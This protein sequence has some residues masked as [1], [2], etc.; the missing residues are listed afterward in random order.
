MEYSSL[1]SDNSKKKNLII[2]EINNSKNYLEEI[3]LKNGFKVILSQN[4][5]EKISISIY[6]KNP[7]LYQTFLNSGIENI[8]LIYIK[9]LIIEKLSKNLSIDQDVKI[10]I[11]ANK[12]LSKL[13]FL[14]S[15]KKDIQYFLEIIGDSLIIENFDFNE[16]LKIKN[17]VT[18]DYSNLIKDK[19]LNLN[20]L[21]ERH[22]FKTKNLQSFF[23]GNS[24]SLKLIK[25]DDVAQYYKENFT[26]ERLLLF[27]NGKIQKNDFKVEYFDQFENKF[28]NSNN[29]EV[30]FERLSNKD[31][32]NEP[33]FFQENIN[34][35]SF[36]SIFYRA[37]SFSND[38]YFA[39]LIV[40]KFFEE[41][42]IKNTYILEPPELLSNMLN[43][44][45]YG[46]VLFSTKNRDIQSTL[47]SFKKILDVQ[48]R[49]FGY[50]TFYK[51]NSND[52]VKDYKNQN[53]N[54]TF[55][56]TSSLDLEN[57]KEKVYNDFNFNELDSENKEIKFV[58]AYF[59]AGQIIDYVLIKE[60]IDSITDKDLIKIFD[61]YFFNLSWGV[62]TNPETSKIISK[63]F[64][65]R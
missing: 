33:I 1:F 18:L 27:V 41:N 28:K 29:K 17:Q 54:K 8:L 37:P 19:K 5:N 40:L 22:I 64:F 30:E 32:N 38:E 48:K 62:L 47:L 34:D 65:Y 15:Q 49:Q 43:I 59:L 39:Y 46:T 51:D 6:L 63:D 20:Q 9:N 3:T 21:L 52:L 16:I 61:N 35:I 45:N 10:S 58:S 53:E 4:N 25:P 42:L 44:T 36:F 24:L 2:K 23:Y 7:P 13:S 14:I 50:F 12:D 55:N 26:I 60:K 11:F 56:I 31:F 57:L